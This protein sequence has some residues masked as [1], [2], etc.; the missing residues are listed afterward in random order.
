[1]HAL[2]YS[3]TLWLKEFCCKTH[4]ARVAAELLN[5][6]VYEQT[7]IIEQQFKHVT[8]LVCNPCT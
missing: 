6:L 2:C 3:G 8:P 7:G 5:V 1:M 4:A